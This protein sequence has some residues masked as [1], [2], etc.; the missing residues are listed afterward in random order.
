M[1]GNK[2]VM[3]TVSGFNDYL[4]AMDYYIKFNA[5][6]NVR[7]PAGKKMITFII[8]NENLEILNNDG[9]PERYKLYFMENYL[10]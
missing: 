7:N 2:Y 1:A 8:N 10:K 4:Q 9:N 6:K 5:E 3:I